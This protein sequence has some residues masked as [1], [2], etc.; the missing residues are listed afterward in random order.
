MVTDV[1]DLLL[2][3]NML[4]LFKLKGSTCIV[5]STTYCNFEN[6]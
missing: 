5:L 2:T 3:I 6:K 1:W 4:I